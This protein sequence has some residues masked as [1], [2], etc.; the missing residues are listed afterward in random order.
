[1]RKCQ[2]CGEDI[3]DIL[4]TRRTESAK[5]VTAS[6]ELEELGGS[7]RFTI[8]CG[9]VIVGREHG[10]RECLAGKSFVSRIHAKFIVEDG[11]L[12][13]E[14][15]SSVNYTFVNNVRI[16]N[17]RVQLNVGDQ[18][19]FGGVLVD[20]NRQEKAAYFMVGLKE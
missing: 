12:Y 11:I 17:G 3:S 4:P 1:M 18:V 13:I 19:S 6:Y 20:G 9:S 7:Y 16:P 2:R 10:M 8:P 14:N 5:V 15:L